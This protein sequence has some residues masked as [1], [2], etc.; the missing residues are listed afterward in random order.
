MNKNIHLLP[1]LI[2]LLILCACQN[3]PPTETALPEL[4]LVTYERV[5]VSADIHERWVIYEDG[6]V[7]KDDGVKTVL[8]VEAVAE[9]MV[10]IEA[11]GFFEM[12]D[13]Y[14]PEGPQPDRSL[15]ALSVRSDGGFKTV[16]TMEG[17]EPES[18][19]SLIEYLDAWVQQASVPAV[20]VRP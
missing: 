2:L 15:Y 3:A 17:A 7:L 10:R 20:V 4:P 8:P 12:E 19:Q 9:L 18:L 16:V 13:V 5:I 6:T 14:L 1:A 11:A